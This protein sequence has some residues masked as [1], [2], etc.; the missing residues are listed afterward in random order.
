MIVAFFTG[1]QSSNNLFN[2]S[3]NQLRGLVLTDASS[4]A[5][6]FFQRDNGLFSYGMVLCPSLEIKA[7]I[8][9]PYWTEEGFLKTAFSITSVSPEADNAL[10]SDIRGPLVFS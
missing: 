9:S 8:G 1:G 4:D 6:M 10:P 7:P 3:V 5:L 2:F